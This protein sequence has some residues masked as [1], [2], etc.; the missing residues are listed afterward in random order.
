[1]ICEVYAATAAAEYG[2]EGGE[3]S[4][5]EE[6]KGQVA[7]MWYPKW[8]QETARGSYIRVIW[9][10]RAAARPYRAAA[11]PSSHVFPDRAQNTASPI[12]IGLS[13]SPVA[14]RTP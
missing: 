5:R 13:D 10:L 6:S 2:Q 12:A 7:W 11:R 8:K 3:G 9:R 4:V 1:M 14:A